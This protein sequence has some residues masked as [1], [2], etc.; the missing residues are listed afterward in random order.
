MM[1]TNVELDGIGDIGR[2]TI[3]PLTLNNRI[4]LPGPFP[5]YQM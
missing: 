5:L 1:M 2:D 4:L 3:M